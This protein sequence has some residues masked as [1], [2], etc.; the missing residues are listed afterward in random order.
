MR[1]LIGLV[2]LGA[3]AVAGDAALRAYVEG[4]VEVQLAAEL[5]SARPTVSLGGFPFVAGLLSARIPSATVEADD[6]R[7]AGLRIERLT[8][9][10]DGVEMSLDAGDTSA[11]VDR[12]DGAARIDLDVLA[13]YVE[14]RTQLEVLGFDGEQITVALR[15]R[16]ST[17]PLRLEGGAIVIGLPSIDDFEVPLPRVLRGIE[18]ETLELSGGSVLLTFALRNATLRSI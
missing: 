14:R 1:W 9:D 4:R 8:L 6:L 2:I 7:R 11:H 10:L 16:R 17:V 5:D 18:Y 15:G 12:G 13:A 3:V